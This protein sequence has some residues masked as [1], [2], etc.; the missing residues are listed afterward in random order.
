[1]SAEDGNTALA[2][3]SWSAGGSS[4]PTNP[5]YNYTVLERLFGYLLILLA[6]ASAI[7]ASL[8]L[9]LL[10]SGATAGAQG[11]VNVVPL[12]ASLFLATAFFLGSRRLLSRH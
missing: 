10:V 2:N 4:L 11:H 1:M 5:R 6:I 9:L 3:A 8:L 12:A 7:P